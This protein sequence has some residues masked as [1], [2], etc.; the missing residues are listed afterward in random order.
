[1]KKQYEVIDNYLPQEDF[2]KIK[3]TI[4]SNDFAWFYNEDVTFLKD[5]NSESLYFIHLLYTNNQPNS[6]H[7]DI[8]MPILKKIN[9][10]AII[11][12]KANLYPNLNKKIE[13][14]PHIDYDYEHKGALFYINTNNGDTVLNDG[15]RIEAV[16][17]R[18]LFFNPNE[19]HNSTHCTDKKARFNININYF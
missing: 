4:M 10:K 14:K 2:V 17:N 15:T 6:N 8:V 3:S 16:E 13:N 5:H 18:I 9:P 19:L 11:R 7:F 1:M 12:I